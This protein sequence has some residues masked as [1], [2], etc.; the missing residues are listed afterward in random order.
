MKQ[1]IIA[2]LVFL[3]VAFWVAGFLA[4][5]IHSQYARTVVTHYDH[6]AMTR[7][8]EL[9][10]PHNYTCAVPLDKMD[11]WYRVEF[12]GRVVYV[13]ANDSCKEGVDLTPAAFNRLAP[14]ERGVIMCKVEE[15]K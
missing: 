15:V 10:N 9:Y 6:G 7:S 14:L 13:Y 11:K 1:N 12:N 4:G 2:F 5:A 3:L 8:G